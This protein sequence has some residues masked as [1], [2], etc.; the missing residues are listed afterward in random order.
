MLYH[1]KRPD[2]STQVTDIAQ[3]PERGKEIRR[4]RG[5]EISMIFQE[6]MSSLSVMHTVGN[7]IMET[8]RLHEDI[9]KQDAHKRA[10]D[11]LRQVEIPRPDRIVDE[12][13]FRLSGGMRQRAMIA[14][15]LACNP[16]LL[17]ADEPTTALDVTTQSQILKLLHS[18]QAQYGMA[19]LFITHDLGVVAEIADDVAVMYLGRIAEHCDAD[20]VFNEPKHPY[21]QALL[22]SIPRIA[23]QRQELDPIS[24][25]VPS[26]FRRPTGCTFHPRCSQRMAHC[27][28]IEP[29]LTQ[30]NESHQVRCLIY[31][32]AP[33]PEVETIQHG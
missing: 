12:Y 27:S 21:T 28:S 26:P 2:G 6:P 3:L 16:T 14:M 22:R 4:I 13:P 15:A 25:M 23:A 7:Q 1:H 19:M 29:A 31:E 5:K 30:L 33:D 32:A 17:I 9:S 24:G 18:L 20:T 10:I 8:L 11:L